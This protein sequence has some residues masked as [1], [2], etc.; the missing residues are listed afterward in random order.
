[1]EEQ[2][3]ITFD[4]PHGLQQNDRLPY[5]LNGRIVNGNV[6]T[7]QSDTVVRLSPDG[8]LDDVRR[9]FATS[10]TLGDSSAPDAEVTEV[11]NTLSDDE[12]M[13]ALHTDRI[14]LGGNRIQQASGVPD[15]PLTFR[16]RPEDPSTERAPK[17]QRR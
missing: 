15:A 8:N 5:N 1:M 9:E 10:M 12:E 11:A 3:I 7:V 13:G 16:N 14:E 17:V 4:K 2:V 6:M